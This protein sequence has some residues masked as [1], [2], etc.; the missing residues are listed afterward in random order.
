MV[1]LESADSR[2]RFAS[3]NAVDLANIIASLVKRALKVLDQLAFA[4]LLESVQ[5]QNVKCFVNLAGVVRVQQLAVLIPG[6]K[7]RED[8]A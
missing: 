3:E 7:G 8:S 4:A 2:Q 5:R 6:C 1:G